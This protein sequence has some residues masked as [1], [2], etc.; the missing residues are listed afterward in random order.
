MEYLPTK[1]VCVNRSVYIYTEGLGTGFTG[2]RLHF[3]ILLHLLSCACNCVK[4]TGATPSFIWNMGA[5]PFLLL[6]YVLAVIY[7]H[8]QLLI[9]GPLHFRGMM[10][11]FTIIICVVKNC[12]H[13]LT[14]GAHAQQ[15]LQYLVCVSV[16][17]SVCL[18][19]FSHYRLRGDL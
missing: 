2:T 12:M 14:L 10:N 15:G 16:C 11:L 3:S 8:V 1:V 13:L 19:L 9:S 6:T 4:V 5:Q 7:T 17:L 18:R